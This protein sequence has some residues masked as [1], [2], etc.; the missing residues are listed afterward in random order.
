[1]VTSQPKKVFLVLLHNCSFDSV[2]DVNVN[3]FRD[4]GLI[5]VPQPKGVHKYSC[6]NDTIREKT[7]KQTYIAT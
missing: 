6:M 7:K 4:G 1:M 3:I 5:K 2:M